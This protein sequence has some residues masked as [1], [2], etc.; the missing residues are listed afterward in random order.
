MSIPIRCVCGR[1]L[2]ADNFAGARAECPT[3]GRTL[4]IPANPEAKR[5]ARRRL[6]PP[7]S[8]TSN[9]SKS[10]SSST[11]RRPTNR[12]QRLT[13]I[14]QHS[15]PALRRSPRA[16]SPAACSRPSSTRSIQWMLMIG[17]GLCVLGLIVWLVSL[18]VFKDPHVL[19]GVLGV[20]TLAILGAG[21]YV[22]SSAPASASPARPSRSSAASSRRL[23]SRSARRRI[24]SRSTA[25][26]GWAASS[27]A[28]STRRP[29]TSCT[30]PC[31]C[32]PLKLASRSRRFC[33][34]PTSAKSPTPRSSPSSS[35]PSA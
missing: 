31:S 19:A 3:C 30:T 21:W 5:P 7:R 24:S 17:G 29:S 1:H 22:A 35:W 14:H 23:T 10:P 34:S 11:R 2:L 13:R 16:P 28:S 18:G 25:T 27:A 12:P 6:P 20:G 26:F 32:M 9:R 4:Q 8:P 15:P 33:Y